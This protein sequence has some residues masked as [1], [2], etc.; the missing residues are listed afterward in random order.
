MAEYLSRLLSLHASHNTPCGTS[1]V[2]QGDPGELVQP[3]KDAVREDLEWFVRAA[4]YRHAYQE[5]DDVKSL[6]SPSTDILAE[7]IFGYSSNQPQFTQRK[8][9][10]FED[11]LWYARVEEV[12]NR[13]SFLLRALESLVERECVPPASVSIDEDVINA[14]ADREQEFLK[15]AKEFETRPQDISMLYSPVIASS[16]PSFLA[17]AKGELAKR[18]NRLGRK[19]SVDMEI[20]LGAA[21]SLGSALKRGP[22][23]GFPNQ[24]VVDEN[25]LIMPFN[26][27]EDRVVVIYAENSDIEFWNRV[28]DVKSE[29][30]LSHIQDFIKASS[31][32]VF[33]SSPV[34]VMKQPR[35]NENK[36]PSL[37]MV[38]S[39]PLSTAG[40]INETS[41]EAF[42]VLLSGE[43][44]GTW[45]L[46][47]Q[48]MTVTEMLEAKQL[49]T[50]QAMGNLY[51]PEQ[52]TKLI[53][54]VESLPEEG[55]DAF[56][57]HPFYL[58][59]PDHLKTRVSGTCN[60][61]T[62]GA[63][64]EE[65]VPV[66][67]RIGDR[68]RRCCTRLDEFRTPQGITKEG[69][70]KE[71]NEWRKEAYDILVK[72]YDE[73]VRHNQNVE[74]R[75]SSIKRNVTVT[76][77]DRL[78]ENIRGYAKATDALSEGVSGCLS[79]QLQDQ[80]ANLYDFVNRTIPV[81][82]AHKEAYEMLMNQLGDIQ[83][84]YHLDE[85]TER[86]NASTKAGK[87]ILNLGRRAVHWARQVSAKAMHNKLRVVFMSL[88]F[89]GAFLPLI[90][91]FGKAMF[92][93][94]VGGGALAFDTQIAQIAFQTV[95]GTIC[96]MA[97][98]PLGAAMLTKFAFWFVV[99]VLGGSAVCKLL[100]IL[101]KMGKFLLSAV[102]S[103]AMPWL[104]FASRNTNTESTPVDRQVERTAEYLRRNPDVLEK[105][106]EALIEGGCHGLFDFLKK[107]WFT[108]GE[109]NLGPS[110]AIMI[111][112]ALF[113]YFFRWIVG[114]LVD[115]V[116]PTWVLSLAGRTADVVVNTFTNPSQ[117]AYNLATDRANSRYFD[118]IFP[119]E[120][121]SPE[122]EAR[123]QID[124]GTI[125]Q[126]QQ[127]V[128]HIQNV[129][130]GS[131]P[132]MLLYALSNMHYWVPVTLAGMNLA[133]TYVFTEDKD[134]Q[135]TD[136]SS[137]RT[138]LPP[139]PVS[140][141]ETPPFVS[142]D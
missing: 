103:Y 99:H 125:R 128:T 30:L 83:R 91:T 96:L 75:F 50:F 45:I 58:N 55:D 81:Y 2:P 10:E 106:N 142:I 32:V 118:R 136:P 52:G 123:Q 41:I 20:L 134:L 110:D 92:A 95:V 63:C 39:F 86:D 33:G 53:Q 116:C 65:T 57:S 37:Q 4:E 120:Q 34:S 29:Q 74:Q 137:L 138:S 15:M 111:Y 40:T 102:S 14:M 54:C 112:F 139:A 12:R 124:I 49:A 36:A 60:V 82:E 44:D 47:H 24:G 68:L 31:P 94:G 62:E 78:R 26:S 113:A 88:V 90:S 126:V 51:K 21:P 73:I 87:S 117:A 135:E 119:M 107:D 70:T 77:F 129:P 85:W 71:Y 3:I 9:E 11:S 1:Q 141:L 133:F 105:G 22:T 56:R 28:S 19:E 115:W 127:L 23:A 48:R 89:C 121:F 140:P 7:E 59:V 97:K 130:P 42:T 8:D 79:D 69:Y 132:G 46:T 72:M 80:C 25:P 98:E 61:P 100:R 18:R 67:I 109:I 6:Y 122:R 17:R 101:L 76:V 93:G 35:K 16:V 43:F 108:V 13:V 131:V 84:G 38:I 114:L 5:D 27:I 64:P 104:P 66:S